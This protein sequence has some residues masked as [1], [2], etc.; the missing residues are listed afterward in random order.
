MA[1]HQATLVPAEPL[2]ATSASRLVAVHGDTVVVGDPWRTTMMGR[3]S[4]AVYIFRRSAEG[5][6]QEAELRSP[7]PLPFF[8]FGETVAVSGDF[9]AIGA[10]SN[11][12]DG[13]FPGTVYCYTR[14]GNTWGS[15]MRLTPSSPLAGG[16][17]GASLALD[18]NMLLV[19]TPFVRPCVFAFQHDGTIWQPAGTML[20]HD[21]RA[22]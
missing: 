11:G 6:V 19:D 20:N 21:P 16:R 8:G 15:E 18:R 9:L 12:P 1:I 5:W 17:F 4:G 3:G 10:P 22:I 7:E 14:S 13:R 2:V